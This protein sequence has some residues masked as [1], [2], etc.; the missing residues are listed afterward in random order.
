MMNL[1]IIKFPGKIE[2]TSDV[3]KFSLSWQKNPIFFAQINKW[4]IRVKIGPIHNKGV[5]VE[6]GIVK[7]FERTRPTNTIMM[8][9]NLFK[10]FNSYYGFFYQ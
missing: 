5:E 3:I 8:V 2:S 6:Q 9:G 7:K 10:I 4:Q 1:V